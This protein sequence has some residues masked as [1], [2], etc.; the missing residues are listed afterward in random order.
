MMG[1]VWEGR[2]CYIDQ[3]QAL[4]ACRPI[5][6][7]PEVLP[8]RGHGIVTPL[9]LDQWK[10][11]L[12]DHPDASFAGYIVRGIQRGFR[13]GFD[14]ASP[15]RSAVANM[16]T[17]N[18][19]VIIDY[20]EREVSLDRMVR[21]PSNQAVHV[22]VSPMGLIPKK[23]P[24]KWRMIVDLSSPDGES[25]NDGIRRE[26]SSL[27]YTTVD[28][29]SAL[30]LATARGA[31]LVKADVKEA[32]RAV[33]VHPEDQPLLGLRWNEAVYMDRV[34]PFG[35]R[36]AP[37]IFTAVADAIQ[38]VLTRHGIT[39]SLHY[40]DDYILVTKD[41]GEAESQKQV[42][43][44]V[45]GNLGVPLELAKLEGPSTCLVFLGIEVDS[46]ALQI[47]LPESKL[48]RLVKELEDAIGRKGMLKRELQSLTGLL[49]H[50]AKVVRPGRTFMRSLHALQS[51][52]SRKVR[53]NVAARA[54]I[55]WWYI[56]VRRWNGVS[57]LWDLGLGKL[58]PEVRVY[59][60]ASGGWGCGAYCLP[61]WF[62]LRWPPALAAASI[63]VKELIPVVIAAALY[64]NQWAGKVVLFKV[65]NM[66]VVGIIQDIYS[67]ESHLIHLVRLLSFF[68]AHYGFWFTSEHIPGVEN[69]Y[70]DAISRDNASLFLSQVPQ[71]TQCPSLIPQPL[72]D[73]IIQDTPWTSID[74]IQRFSS[75][76]PLR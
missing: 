43:Q 50:A 58:N 46:V 34:L 20:L 48:V 41:R 1:Q 31:W 38:W 61:H 40:L 52:P 55:I 26:L 72:V 35:L 54:D 22:H 2:Y 37:K 69:G 63:Q 71:A 47:R 15:L 30:I 36:S 70:A 3:L 23:T 57:M 28:H 9:R 17:S 76:L 29:L 68:A 67:R 13:I 32:Y 10:R 8:G 45:F 60:D 27:A 25:V 16:P 66:S 4:E 6:Q 12:A 14:R 18:P 7:I 24:G 19:R 51:V 11:E 73:L 5:Q 64:G 21:V 74:W 56:F 49:Q 42:L 62:S 39:Q 33:P 59:S 44:T 53:L 75:T 65:D